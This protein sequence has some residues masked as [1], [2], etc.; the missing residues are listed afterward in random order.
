MKPMAP[1]IPHFTTSTIGRPILNV[2]L[3]QVDHAKTYILKLLVVP[4]TGSMPNSRNM[5]TKLCFVCPV[6]TAA[7]AA[8]CRQKHAPGRPRA[9]ERLQDEARRP[10]LRAQ[11]EWE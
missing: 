4:G 11:G 2:F 3:E 10:S 5:C 8:C 6:Y 7:A 9:S 1:D